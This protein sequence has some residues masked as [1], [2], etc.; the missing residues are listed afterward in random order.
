MKQTFRLL[1]CSLFLVMV[2]LA[3]GCSKE[4]IRHLSSEACLIAQ[5]TT[6]ADVLTYMG[7]PK[8]KNKT[9]SGEVWIF[10][11]EHKSLFK[12]TPVLK[13]FAGSISYDLVYITFT[14][15]IV[16]NCQ[17]RSVSEEEYG[18]SFLGKDSVSE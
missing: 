7:T 9:E 15:D 11:E 3:S 2:L 5:G 4:P 6:R 14:G 10:V 13:W 16:T 18:K 17:Y 12:K 1:L 8:F